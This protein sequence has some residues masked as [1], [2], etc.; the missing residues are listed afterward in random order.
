[1]LRK[2]RAPATIEQALAPHEVRLLELLAQGYTYRGA[3]KSLRC[4]LRQ[5]GTTFARSTRNSTRTP[6]ANPHARGSVAEL[7]GAHAKKRADPGGAPA[8]GERVT[9]SRIQSSIRAE[10]RRS[11]ETTQETS[12]DELCPLPETYSGPQ[13]LSFHQSVDGWIW[14]GSRD[15]V[16]TLAG[17]AITEFRDAK[18]EPIRRRSTRRRIGCGSN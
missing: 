5:S 8:P 18:G 16:G 14:V 11:I 7:P 10:S 2:M 9:P 1:M 6:L 15:K 4:R 3:G 13:R 12:T 17:S